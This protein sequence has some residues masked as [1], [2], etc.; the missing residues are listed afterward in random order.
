MHHSTSRHAPES[1]GFSLI[2]VAIAI[3]IVAFAFVALLGLMPAG[4][5]SF[6]SAIDTSNESW[7]M[8]GINS[9]VQATEWKKIKDLEYETFYYNEEGRLTDTKS[10]PSSDERVK[11]SRLYAVKVLIDEKFIRPDNVS[12]VLKHS[13][14]VVVLLASITN[15]VAMKDFD[16]TTSVEA[17]SQLRRASPVR[18]RAFLVA[19]MDSVK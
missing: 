5:S 12:D 19:R 6:R 8:Q 1:R 7:I 10:N 14:R 9:M 13:A 4:L 17:V 3:G 15:P 11:S 18:I 16:Q 2:E